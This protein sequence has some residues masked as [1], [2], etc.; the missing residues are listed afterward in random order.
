[1]ASAIEKSRGAEEARRANEQ[2][3]GENLSLR[4]EV[5]ARF[6]P[7]GIVGRSAAITKVLA[8]AERAAQV[9]S[10]VLITGE[11]GTGKEL[12]ARVLHHSGRQKTGPFVAVNC[13]AIPETLLE[14]ELFGHVKGAF[15]GALQYRKGRF[16]QAHGGTL[17][18]DEIGEMP[19]SQ[20]VALLSVIAN[21]EFTPVGA[22]K[23]VP[24]DVRI[25]SATNQNLLKLIGEGRFREDLYFRLNVIPIEVPSLRE[26]KADIPALA[27]HF[28]RKF[29]GLQERDVP[30]MSPE[31]LAALIQSDWPGNVR[32]L[33]NYVERIMAMTPGNVLFPAPLPND[34]ENRAESVRLPR[35]RKL[36]DLVAEVERRAIIE[37][38]ERADGNQSRAARELGMTEQTLRY[39]LRKYGPPG[40]RQVRRTRKNR[41]N[42]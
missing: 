13:G 5:G 33:E 1:M 2:L 39:R 6:Q 40:S 29:A 32:E 30:E 9:S 31:F 17:F 24:V 21:R 12:I 15:T 23:A 4:Q 26:R 20:Q 19:L 22:S 27:A 18:L 41:R 42:A 11:N 37:A 3:V 14:S 7:S 8:V 38:L 25:I 16:E 10:T 34:L 35:K 36:A 28:V